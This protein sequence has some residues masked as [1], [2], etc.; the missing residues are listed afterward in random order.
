MFAETLGAIA[1]KTKITPNAQK[2]MIAGVQNGELAIKINA[3]PENGK[4]NAALIAFMAKT[5]KIA[6]SD[7]AIVRGETS[8]RKV[9]RLP[10]SPQTRAKLEEIANIYAKDS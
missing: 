10:N 1:L 5:L 3:A 4:A 6:K 9:L 2:D 7:I 8:R